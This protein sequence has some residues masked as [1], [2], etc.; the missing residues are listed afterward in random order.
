MSTTPVLGVLEC[1][2]YTLH[3]TVGSGSFP[4]A[5][6]G[7]VRLNGARPTALVVRSATQGSQA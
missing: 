5:S 6:G 4:G 1:V 3:L 7:R 2:K